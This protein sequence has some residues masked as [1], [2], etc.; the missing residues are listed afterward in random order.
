[1]QSVHYI[2]CVLAAVIVVC[3][4]A[5]PL[6]AQDATFSIAFAVDTAYCCV[7]YIGSTYWAGRLFSILNS[8]G[9]DDVGF[10]RV[11]VQGSKLTLLFLILPASRSPRFTCIVASKQ[12]SEYSLHSLFTQ[13]NSLLFSPL[14]TSQQLEHQT[15]Y[16]T[17]FRLFNWVV[18]I[19]NDHWMSLWG[20]SGRH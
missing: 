8:W 9:C 16:Q 13:P 7:C 3:C 14:R 18:I 1:M 10:F 6:C 5:L 4:I 2:L 19:H 17:P 11:T 20:G 15:T 12:N